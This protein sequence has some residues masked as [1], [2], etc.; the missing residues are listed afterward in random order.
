MSGNHHFMSSLALLTEATT[1]MARV[2][3]FN[4]MDNCSISALPYLP[5]LLIGSH[6]SW[7]VDWVLYFCAVPGAAPL[8]VALLWLAV[9]TFSWNALPLGHW[10]CFQFLQG[11]KVMLNI[12][13][14][15]SCNLI[16]LLVRDLNVGLY[17]ELC[18]FSF[19]WV[20]WE[21]AWVI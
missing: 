2:L 15:I 3:H 17:L 16:R 10:I 11:V 7:L 1:F 19:C 14:M 4:I 13:I 5:M 6:M 8:L 21:G 20:S 9:G 12:P 18:G